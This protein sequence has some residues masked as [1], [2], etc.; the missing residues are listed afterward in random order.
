MHDFFFYT[1]LRVVKICFFRLD[2]LQLGLRGCRRRE[3]TNKMA[4]E[5]I[6]V[7]L[8]SD[9]LKPREALGARLRYFDRADRAVQNGGTFHAFGKKDLAQLVPKKNTA[10]TDDVCYLKNIFQTKHRFVS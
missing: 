3:T 6:G 2:R 7:F 8:F 9:W 5:L 10:R 1:W 4:Q